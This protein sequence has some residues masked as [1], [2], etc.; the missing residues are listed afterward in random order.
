MY[1]LYVC[2]SEGILI[3]YI[4]LGSFWKV[5]FV[6]FAWNKSTLSKELVYS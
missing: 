3:K 2:V 5:V 4:Y 6:K 1:V